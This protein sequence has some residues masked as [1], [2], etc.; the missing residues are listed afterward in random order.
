MTA[1]THDVVALAS[2][3]TFATLNPPE[4]INI[5]TLGA[6]L[7]GNVVGSLLP[8]LDQAANRLWDITPVGNLTG[9]ILR[10]L[11]VGHRALSHSLIGAYLSYIILSLVLPLIFNPT[12]IDHKLVLGAV[13]IGYISHLVADLITKDG[14]PLLF[15]IKYKF[16][17]PPVKKFRI[18]TGSFVEKFIVF[19]GMLVYIFWFIGSYQP[20]VKNLLKLVVR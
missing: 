16:A 19:P 9:Q 20:E 2:L 6:V 3:I 10:K 4:S 11:F 17:F 15:P 1:R 8:D 18:K 7:V 12:Y 5:V 14:L 13:M